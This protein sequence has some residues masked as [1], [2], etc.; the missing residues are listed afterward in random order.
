MAHSA[1]RPTS[2]RRSALWIVA[3]HVVCAIALGGVF[4]AAMRQGHGP[5][6]LARPA[7]ERTPPARRL[8][9]DGALHLAGSGSNL[10]LTRALSAA[11]VA[12]NPGARV[13]VH[14]SIGSTGGIRAAADRAVDLGLV[15]RPLTARE[16]RLGLT[17][18]PYARVAVVVAAN[19]SVPDTNLSRAGL[20]QLYAGRRTRW[21][22]GSRV[23]VLQRERGDSSHR[24]VERVLP[25]F[26]AVNERAHRRGRW[27]VLYHDRDMQEALL[28]TPGAVGLFDL[29]AIVSQ[30]LSLE[31]LALDGVAPTPDNV[32]S[33][34]Y[35][36][37]KDLA[38]VCRGAPGGAAKRLLRFIHSRAGQRV[39]QSRGYIPLARGLR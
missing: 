22:D 21:S 6:F 28:A 18:L 36:L 9:A 30:E 8:G 33:G 12:A 38:F 4:L 3:G 26:R 16:R 2:T 25:R 31:V 39:I 27:R 14:Q 7:G 19:E 37:H 17:V 10:P 23:T 15:S 1:H 32:R 24:A 35:P 29:G 11:H 13:V 20:L 5:P 34:A